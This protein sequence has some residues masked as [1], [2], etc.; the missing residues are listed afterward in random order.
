MGLPWPPVR[1][2]L[3]FLPAGG[4]RGSPLQLCPEGCC[5]RGRDYSS[6]EALQ[7][8]LP[9][10]PPNSFCSWSVATSTRPL[11]SSKTKWKRIAVRVIVGSCPPPKIF[12]SLHFSRAFFTASEACEFGVS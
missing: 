4:H 8:R 5:L 7:T 1:G 10:S 12:F 11:P 9:H 3:V 2:M 6:K